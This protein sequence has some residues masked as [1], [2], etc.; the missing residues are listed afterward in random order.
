MDRLKG[1][2]DQDLGGIKGLARKEN[3]RRV[4]RIIPKVD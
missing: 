4:L 3:L 1:H 2:L